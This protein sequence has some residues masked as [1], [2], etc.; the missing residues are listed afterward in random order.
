MTRAFWRG[1][2]HGFERTS[3]L[4]VPLGLVAIVAIL[5][6]SGCEV[7]VRHAWVPV[8]VPL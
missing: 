6:L 1:F 7:A 2:L 8:T 5:V 4:A 3:L